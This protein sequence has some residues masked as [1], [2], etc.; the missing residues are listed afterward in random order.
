[1]PRI[2]DPEINTFTCEVEDCPNNANFAVAV[3]VAINPLQNAWLHM[4]MCND[5]VNWEHDLIMASDRKIDR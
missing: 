2:I 3:T 5:H 1:M 4:F